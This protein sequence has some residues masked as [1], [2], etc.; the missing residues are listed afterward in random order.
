[1]PAISLKDAEECVKNALHGIADFSDAAN[2][3]K[4][5][6]SHWHDFHKT[7]FINLVAVCISEKGSRIVLNEGML[8]DFKSIGEFIKFVFENSGFIGEPMPKVKESNG[9]L[10]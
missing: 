4:F 8:D 1:M 9:D 7:V 3:E 2:I 6:F 5:T 10:Q